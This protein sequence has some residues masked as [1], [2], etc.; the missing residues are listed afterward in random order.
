LTLTILVNKQVVTAAVT[1]VPE[2][3]RTVSEP[4]FRNVNS[5][6][7][8]PVDRLIGVQRD[9]RATLIG[10]RPVFPF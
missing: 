1:F 5:Q 8:Q 3:V 4:L 7:F 10:R 6:R 9:E 2:A